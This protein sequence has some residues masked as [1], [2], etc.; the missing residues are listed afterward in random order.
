M[1]YN[2]C[3]RQS[4]FSLLLRDSTTFSEYLETDIIGFCD[5]P[6]WEGQGPNS[7]K[8]YYVRETDKAASSEHDIGKGKTVTESNMLQNKIVTKSNN[9]C[10]YKYTAQTKMNSPTER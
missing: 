4:T 6:A 10:T 8:I 1:G 7:H 3:N 5:F 2:R 9:D